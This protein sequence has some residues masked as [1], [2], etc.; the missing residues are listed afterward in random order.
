MDNASE[1]ILRGTRA[2]AEIGDEAVL[3]CET[4]LKPELF[5]VA[6]NPKLKHGVS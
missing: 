4:G 5:V 1:W 3:C 2:L 6:G